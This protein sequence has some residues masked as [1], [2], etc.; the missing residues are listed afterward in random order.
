MT[1]DPNRLAYWMLKDINRAIRDYQM[2]ADGDRVAVAVSGGKDSLSL[3]RLLDLRRKQVPERYELVAIHVLGDSRGP[4]TPEHPPLLDWLRASGYE[5]AVEPLRLPEGEALPLG[6]QRCTWNRRK[7]LFEA[8]QRLGCRVV[9]FGHHA[10]DLAHTTLLNLLY[11]GKVE[12]MAPRREYFDGALRLV[13][14]LCYTAEGDLRRFARACSQQGD[15]SQQADTSQHA[16][17]AFP[18][19]PPT[20]PQSDHSRRQ[21]ARDLLRQAQ[22]ACPAAK[23][24]LLRAGLK[25][26]EAQ[27]PGQETR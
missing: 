23:T 3:L 26:N 9:A 20:C 22:R 19:P 8:A 13:R 27:D 12:T 21:L 4:E 2:I 14:P 1:P 25:G 11:H 18:P 10:D 24:N 15:D 6:C 16:A 7:A 17:R 5:Y